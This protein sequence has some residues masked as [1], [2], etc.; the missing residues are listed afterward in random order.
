M[1]FMSTSQSIEEITKLRENVVHTNAEIRALSLLAIDGRVTLRS[2]G[3]LLRSFTG[4]DPKLATFMA[5]TQ[6]SIAVAETATIAL[7]SLKMAEIATGVGVGIAVVGTIVSFGYS[8]YEAQ[9]GV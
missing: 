2:F 4:G 6:M 9:T 7:R 3:V 5:N 8:M 1:T